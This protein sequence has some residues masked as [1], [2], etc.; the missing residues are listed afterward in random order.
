MTGMDVMRR[1]RA[2]KTDIDRLRLRRLCAQDAATAATRAAGAAPGASGG[3]S[4]RAERYAVEIDAIDRAIR[5]RHSMR[6]QEAAEAARLVAMLDPAQGM[7][8]H[9]HYVRAQTIRQVAGEMSVSES[10]ARGLIRRA[11]ETL[12]RTPSALGGDETY[13]AACRTYAAYSKK[14]GA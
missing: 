9:C 6:E 2:Y 5:A 12:S 8:M 13:R 3:K 7:A 11:R 4:D 14:E 1:L 10:S